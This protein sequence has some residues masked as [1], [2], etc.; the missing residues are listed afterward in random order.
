MPPDRLRRASPVGQTR[1]DMQRPSPRRRPGGASLVSSLFVIALLASVPVARAG[2][3]DVAP[4]TG[5]RGPPCTVS[6]TEAGELVEGTAGDDILCGFG[7]AD[8]LLGHGGHDTLYG[9]EGDD[10]LK[11]GSGIDQLIGES[12]TDT[13]GGGKGD[14]D[15]AWLTLAPG[16]VEVRLSEGSALGD[17][18]L[19][20]PDAV[21]GLRGVEGAVGTPFGDVMI[22][23]SGPNTFAG[24]GGSDRL[25]GG[26]GLDVANYEFAAGSVRIDL[27]AAHARGADGR[28]VLVGIEDIIGSAFDDQLLG[29]GGNNEIAGLGGDDLMD[30]RG[31]PLD[32]L[33]YAFA[34]VGVT[35]DVRLG[36]AFGEGNDTLAGFERVS[37]SPLGDTLVGDDDADTLHGLGGADTVEGG[38]GP[39]LLATH[40]GND[41]LLG[42]PGRDDLN[43]G[44]GGDDMD[45]GPNADRCVQAG[46]TGTVVNCESTP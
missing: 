4:G 3:T 30:G 28:D 12:G 42:G 20:D 43:G 11:G 15:R 35:V 34:P 17:G 19:G 29:D 44:S 8:R 26:R 33:S 10:A 2:E 32:T 7:G 23:D 9:G 41:E 22:G 38:G 40:G 14:L 18:A 45:G 24:S 1:A 25:R 21:E 27:A 39:D 37:G 13:Y 5:R 6:G 36:A 16:P 46:G 31:S